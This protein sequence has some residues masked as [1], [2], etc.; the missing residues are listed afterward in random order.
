MSKASP[1]Q[2]TNRMP[3]DHLNEACCGLVAWL[4]ETGWLDGAA[5]DQAA[6][7]N[8]AHNRTATQQANSGCLWSVSQGTQGSEGS[9]QEVAVGHSNLQ[10]TLP[11]LQTL[12]VE[13]QVAQELLAP[14]AI[15]QQGLHLV[16]CEWLLALPLNDGAGCTS[17]LLGQEQQKEPCPP[18]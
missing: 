13:S 14:S 17:I 10:S 11:W 8:N 12:T 6:H 3:V 15:L 4:V 1:T 16:A 2:A 18:S 5:E 7:G 9:N